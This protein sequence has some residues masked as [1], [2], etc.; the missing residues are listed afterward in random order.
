MSSRRTASAN[1]LFPAEG[2]PVNQTTTP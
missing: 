2:K 1:V